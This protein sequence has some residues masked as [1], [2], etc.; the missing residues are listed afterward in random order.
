MVILRISRI[1]CRNISSD[2][3]LIRNIGII[4]HI[5][6]G[7]TTTTERLINRAG[8][9]KRA[10][11]VDDGD[12]VM[13]YLPEERERGITI[14]SA[15]ITLPW[16]GC[17]LNLID[18]PGH[19]DFTVEVE[20]SL[21]VMDGA[22]VILDAS[23]G[24]Q[25]QT[26]TVWRQARR[27]GL[28][29]LIFINKM[30]KV[31]AD[32]NKC[33]EDIR[34]H[35]N[36]EPIVLNRP[37]LEDEQFKSVSNILFSSVALTQQISACDDE[38]CDKFYGDAIE[39]GDA[40]VA[41]KRIT[42]EGNKAIAVF[43]GSSAK[44]IGSEVILD[45][46]VDYLPAPKVEASKIFKALAFKVVY[47]PKRT[48]FLVYCRVYSGQFSSNNRQTIYNLNKNGKKEQVGKIMQVM[49]DEF[50]EID[51]ADVGQIV[52]LTG[53]RHTATG[54]TISTDASA[55]V[56]EGI[57]IPSPVISASLEAESTG[58][59]DHLDKCLS[60]IQLEDPSARVATDKTTGQTIL[61]G[62]GELHLEILESRLR[63]EMKA[64]FSTGPIAIALRESF[65]EGFGEFEMEHLL[66][67][68]LFGIKLKGSVKVK[69]S[70]GPETVDLIGEFDVNANVRESVIDA[71]E[72]AFG[73]GPIGGHRMQKNCR[74]MISSLEFSTV[75]SAHVV[76]FEALQSLLKKAAGSCAVV[77]QEPLV[78][79]EITGPED[80]IGELTTDMYSV[81][82]CVDF[83]T[84]GDG[85]INARAPLRNMLGYSS[86][87]RSRTGGMA[88]FTMEA[89]GYCDVVGV[90]GM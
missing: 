70:E 42:V 44:D 2:S 20:R 77:V 3:S 69:I 57:R 79:V 28:K 88:A 48:G 33:L 54:D 11:S 41:L 53:L 51:S 4:A 75:N 63:K 62:M 1:I 56:L 85:K 18:T 7:K 68:E 14:T 10:G 36:L 67:R 87:L 32:L 9:T 49:A 40:Q 35:F 50:I 43:V 29:S 27:L 26:L 80:F 78:K 45:G 22:V 24:V 60:I 5:D 34:D 16:R 61:S 6:A 12:T 25:A 17:R 81:R 66:D 86:W 19:V 21:R 46:I 71:V 90:T 38:F 39:E 47:D 8:L 23:K 30:D 74:I 15:A 76:V 73:R 65:V 84:S 55:E 83:E 59:Q 13:D 37:V 58:A 52:I 82:R 64:K 72:S 89:D 31:G